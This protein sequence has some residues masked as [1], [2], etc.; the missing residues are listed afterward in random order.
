MVKDICKRF[1]TLSM[2]LLLTLTLIPATA[3]TAFAAEDTLL[4]GLSN[5]D[6]GGSYTVS[7]D[8]TTKW[9]GNGTNITGSV[10][11]V[12]GGACGG[13]KSASSTLTLT[14]KKSVVGIL[15]FDYVPTV[16]GGK[17]QIDGQ[18]ITSAG[19]FTKTLEAGDSIKITLESAK[20]VKVTSLQMKNV[21]L[22]ADTTATV[23]FQPAEHGSYTVDGAAVASEVSYTNK[24]TKVYEL[25]AKAESGYKF[26]GWK[27]ATTGAYVSTAASAKLQFD[28]D[29]TII[30][31]FIPEANPVFSTSGS[32]F[33]DLN[34]AVQ[35][36]QETG[37]SLITLISDGILEGNYTIPSG[38]TLLIPFDEAG[39]CYTDT[40]ENTSYLYT[41]PKA[42]RTLTM[43]ENSSLIVEGT[44]SVS[45]KHAAGPANESYGGSPSQFYG[46]IDMMSESSI[47][48][49]NGGALY[50]WG[51]IT[52][53]GNVT[54]ENG[55]VVYEN[56]QISD[57]RGGSATLGMISGKVFPFSQYY[58]QNVEVP[59][60][61]QYG[62]KE[63]VYTS[64]YASSKVQST[65]IEFIGENG[66]FQL[67]EGASFTK[68][69]DPTTD[70]ITFEINGNA[71]LNSL[72]LE[73]MGMSMDSANY[74]LPITSNITLKLHSGTTTINQDVALLPGVQ[75]TID[76]GA[77]LS[78]AAEKNIYVYDLDQWGKYVNESYQF[79]ENPYSPTR[80][81][82]RTNDDLSDVQIDVNG[83]VDTAG[84]VYTTAGGASVIS[85]EGTGKYILTGGAGTEE[86]TQQV[87]QSGSSV[88][89][90]D[91][92]I[93][94]T[95][96]LNQDGTYTETAGAVA[97]DT[98]IYRNG[99]WQKE[100]EPFTG[101]TTDENGTTYLI[102]G[103]KA[104]FSTWQ[105]ID[106]NI[107][108][109][110]EN[111]YI[112]K[113][114]Y[115]TASQDGSYEATFIFDSE[116]G[117]FLADQNGLYD[118]GA[119]TYW[120][121][122]GEI[123]EYPGL[124]RVVKEDGEVNYYYFGKD[125]KAFKATAE[126]DLCKLEKTNG[127]NL[128]SQ[129][130]RFDE[131][132]V[133][134]HDPDT[135]KNGWV[136]EA[137]GNTYNYVDGITVYLGL[138]KKGDDYYYIKSD[139]MVVMDR[140]YEITRTN[141]LLP[142]GVY[143][144][145]ADGKIRLLN[146]IVEEN[147]KL[148]YYVN[149]KRTYAGLILIDG[150]Y[151]YVRSDGEVV[152]NRTYWTTRTNGLMPEGNYTFDADGKMIVPEPEKLNGIVKENNKLW[153]Y[154]DGKRVYKG[155]IQI[156]GDYYYVRSGGEVV[157]DRTYWI[158]R[159][160]GLMPEG[161]YAFDADGKMVK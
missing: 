155:L 45:A 74:I 150:N 96:L 36:A 38:I 65:S 46:Q 121:K 10:E 58:V 47:T 20:G 9:V 14:N 161:N 136:K 63:M 140:D 3:F 126:N 100:A 37:S 31:V 84:F 139:G 157:T 77:T 145:E 22:V 129:Q 107:Y 60:T 85:S 5:P 1:L 18:D 57:F 68:V 25:V 118:V 123:I 66:M 159:T 34:E 76:S 135:S 62:A 115:K 11:G 117:V 116:T 73:V 148:W 138:I 55:S 104:Y 79:R 51:F 42:F 24:S 128:P 53:S 7:A 143:H 4:T 27:N 28:A 94:S 99:K 75:A 48:V 137:D 109:F 43:A 114:L 95:K 29:Q 83:T 151:Y 13:D 110:D 103:E 133:I 12:S 86:S 71:A 132:G 64:L 61:I 70:R 90:V 97:G 41:K 32:V 98:F 59:L 102:N 72:S 69:Y 91:I 106:G 21:F 108:Y 80:T 56:F 122:N 113:G 49:K 160:N 26:G 35:Y 17:I 89:Y 87:T 131:N 154:E 52:G 152:A 92:P 144:F 124:I 142:A 67:S 54:A 120:T 158:T 156:D 111:G 93:T 112:V 8:G 81:H 141:G 134:L 39:T 6:L 23:T 50:A 105:A 127:L 146:G 33:T 78:V 88:S 82:T 16:N 30:P 130:F 101:W 149:S 125:N 2:V 44:L 19:S 147:G 15:S 40:P 119:D 153:Y